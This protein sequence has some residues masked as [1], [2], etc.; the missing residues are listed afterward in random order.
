MNANFA[1]ASILA[2]AG[3]RYAGHN[4]TLPFILLSKIAPESVC[5]YVLALAEDFVGISSPF[6]TALVGFTKA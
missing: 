1:L 4:T 2:Q 5:A 6:R 3:K